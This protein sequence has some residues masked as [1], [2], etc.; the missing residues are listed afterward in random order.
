VNTVMASGK[1]EHSGYLTG[2]LLVAM[3]AMEDSRFQRSVIYLCLHNA[4]GAM[5]LVINQLVDSL[6]FDELLDQ[7]DLGEPDPTQEIRIHFGGP[8]ESG[9]G[10][11]LHSTDYQ[12]ETTVDMENGIGLTATIDIL[13]DIAR[14]DGPQAQLLA[15]GYAGWGPGQLDAEIQDN[16]WLNVP[17]DPSLVF[18]SRLDEKWDQ[19]IARLGVDPSLL[20]SQAGRA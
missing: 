16:A 6:T 17:A 19:A 3:P 15:L 12:Q 11:V 13:R 20:S 10:F 1:R 2:Q 4:E 5:G 9:R 18:N 8:V 14:G 7:L